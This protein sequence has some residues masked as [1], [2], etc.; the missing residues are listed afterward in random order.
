MHAAVF[1]LRSAYCH[2]RDGGWGVP[3]K[4]RVVCYHRT[5]SPRQSRYNNGHL[6]SDSTPSV[7]LDLGELE[8]T[9]TDRRPALKEAEEL[10]LRLLGA[11]DVDLRRA[12]PALLGVYLF[13]RKSAGVAPHLL[14]S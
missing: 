4:E 10:L 5:P 11:V 8:N 14:I 6:D 2:A 13:L 3:R 12:A 1:E 9:S 7:A